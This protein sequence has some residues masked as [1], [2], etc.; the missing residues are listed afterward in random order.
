MRTIGDSGGPIV[1]SSPSADNDDIELKLPTRLCT[2]S[3]PVKPLLTMAN[4]GMDNKDETQQKKRVQMGAR[5]ANV[6]NR[7]GRS[8]FWRSSHSFL[9]SE[10]QNDKITAIV[11]NLLSPCLG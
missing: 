9:Y 6:R 5:I 11:R 10:S 2:W 1:S 8:Q 3:M 4:D 7:S